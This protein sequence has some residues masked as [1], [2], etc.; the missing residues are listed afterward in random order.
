MLTHHLDNKWLVQMT[1]S[2]LHVLME[3]ILKAEFSKP[4]LY[5][6]NF[7]FVIIL[8]L[9]SVEDDSTKECSFL[10]STNT[11]VTV[12][13]FVSAASSI[14]FS[15]CNSQCIQLCENKKPKHMQQSPFHASL[16]FTYLLT[17][18]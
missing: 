10:H 3:H 15:G 6:S 18:K 9:Y 16:A 13:N 11:I 7:Y 17:S 1:I 5:G 8:L 2:F 4:Y 12:T 14:H